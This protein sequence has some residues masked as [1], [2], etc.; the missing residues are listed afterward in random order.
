MPDSLPTP[1]PGQPAPVLMR[2][3]KRLLGPLVRLLL[4][5]QVTFPILA[6]LLK[7]VYVEEATR[8][9]ALPGRPQTISRLSLLT[10]IHRKD[11]K[12]LQNEEV[13]PDAPPANVSLGAELVL[14]WTA[15]PGYQTRDGQPL[16]LPRLA[17]RASGPSFESLVESVSK[18]IRPRAILD[19]WLR[20]GIAT[21]DDED[22]VHLETNAF[23]PR[24]GFE[25]KVYYLGRN[26]HDHLATVEHNLADGD[27]PM[28][29]RSVY[30]GRLRP[31]SVE[32][33]ET[34]ANEVGMEALQRVNRRAR[35]LQRADEGHSDAKERMRFGIYFYRAHVDG[36]GDPD[37]GGSDG[38]A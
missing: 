5:H 7:S 11:V 19:E 9:F 21:I 31:G 27:P 6:N 36:S 8:A 28:L 18:D 33:L 37:E 3:L 34:L 1:G 16:A 14:R 30:Y 10:G 29:E 23:V 20:L 35:S 24:H 26:L 22:R 12:H 4:A 38:A 15:E 25:E 13:E 17:G 32:T 2:A